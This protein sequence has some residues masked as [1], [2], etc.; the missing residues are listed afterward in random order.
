M[1]VSNRPNATTAIAKL[2]GGGG[3]S[4]ALRVIGYALVEAAEPNSFR[5][6]SYRFITYLAASLVC[7][8]RDFGR[9]LDAMFLSDQRTEIPRAAMLGGNFLDRHTG[10]P[11][12]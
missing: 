1:P 10:E 3:C 12:F 2:N 8:F 9:T 4:M 6:I 7:K 11:V 5:S